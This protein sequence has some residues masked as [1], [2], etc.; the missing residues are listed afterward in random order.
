MAPRSLTYSNAISRS[1]YHNVLG[2]LAT[3]L[4]F[5]TS[6]PPFL[7]INHRVSIRKPNDKAS[8][9]PIYTTRLMAESRQSPPIMSLGLSMQEDSN[10][11][12]VPPEQYPV[13]TSQTSH[14]DPRRRSYPRRYLAG[15]GPTNERVQQS[16]NA[17][18][19][20]APNLAVL[21]NAGYPMFDGQP[22]SLFQRYANLLTLDDLSHFF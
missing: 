6:H 10:A 18:G 14:N 2:L 11:I 13:A 4:L 12:Y 20:H 7:H 8:R 16:S 5:K 22:T 1:F 15:T 17:L 21:S 9:L 3:I 19:V